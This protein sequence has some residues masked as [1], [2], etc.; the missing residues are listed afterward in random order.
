MTT[1]MRAALAAVCAV[2]LARGAEPDGRVFDVPR[3]EGVVFDGQDADW[4]RAG[5][6]VEAL[7]SVDG[8][9]RPVD[10]LEGRVTLGWNDQGLLLLLRV[11]DDQFVEGGQTNQLYEGDSVELYL[12]DRRGGR[13][14]VQ[15][16][17]APGVAADHPAPRYRLYD[18][19]LD[20]SARTKEPFLQV[21]RTRVAGGYQLEALLPWQNLG[22]APT[23]GTEVACQIYVNDRDPARAD[24]RLAWYPAL[25][26]FMDTTRMHRLRLAK[27]AGQPAAA[28]AHGFVNRAELWFSVVAAERLA[29]KPVVVRYNNRTI[30]EGT[31]AAY[32]G[33][34]HACLKASLPAGADEMSRFEVLVD[35]QPL[36]ST[37]LLDLENERGEKKLPLKF[38]F[39][40]FCF[41]GKRLPAGGFQDRA[42]VERMLGPHEVGVA[43]YDNDLRRVATAEQPGRYGAVVTV[44]PRFHPPLWRY[45]TLFNTTNQVDWKELELGVEVRLPESLGL[46][47]AM[48]EQHSAA[49]GVFM[50]KILI[51]W[52]MEREEGA[53]LLSWLATQPKERPYT[54]RNGYWTANLRW[55]HE[56]R[57]AAGRLTPLKYWVELPKKYAPDAGRK[58]PA[59]LYLHGIGDRGTP[60]ALLAGATAVRLPAEQ[61]PD[62]FIVIAPRCPAESTWSLPALEDLMDEVLEKYPIDESR[63]YLT[64]VSMGGFACWALLAEHPTWFAAAV[65]ICGGGDPREAL[66]FA[67]VP[68]WVVHGA[69]DD[70][71]PPERSREMVEA[72]RTE[73]GRVR[74]DEIPKA[75]HRCWDS[76]YSSEELYDWLLKQVRGKPQQPMSKPAATR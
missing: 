40:P 70:V 11:M 6:Q 61:K 33:R 30:M 12:A 28:V 43:Y 34:A 7:T 10:D 20:P 50:R 67:Q 64:G 75:G 55:Q 19:R 22:I 8:W 35:G 41:A 54:E 14:M 58:Y 32:G 13:L 1:W 65:P 2:A 72:L 56:L 73:R 31:T 57:R 36:D 17:I 39:Q 69:K 74:Y 9:V 42:A 16:V 29:G 37:G 59:I 27:T 25:G 38:A 47:P 53:I 68:I 52:L 24:F 26:T 49:L 44:T 62:T 46:N 63:V 5:F 51:E 48:E 3:I 45:F 66:R 60:V 71:V 76:V 23:A 15:A 4:E 18:Y 21:A